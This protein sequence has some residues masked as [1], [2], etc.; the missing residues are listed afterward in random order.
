[1]GRMIFGG[2]DDE[3]TLQAL[4]ELRSRRADLAAL[5]RELVARARRSGTSWRE[6][7]HALGIATQSAHERFRALDP[8]SRRR[9]PDPLKA[10][11][12]ELFA[13]M[14]S[15]RAGPPEGSDPSGGPEN[16][17]AG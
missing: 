12:D 6:I 16:A 8:S 13:S 14:R 4:E 5:E 3:R 9:T 2:R 1:M 17:G 10:E 15:T 7:A 11:L